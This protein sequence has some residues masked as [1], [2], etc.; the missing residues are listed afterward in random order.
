MAASGEGT[1]PEPESVRRAVSTVYYAVF[2]FIAQAAADCF[3]G[4]ANRQTARYALIYRSFDHRYMKA[5]CLAL[6]ASTLNEK[7][8]NSLGRTTVSRSIVNFPTIFP[9]LQQA[10]HTADY[11]PTDIFNASNV[12][13]LAESAETAIAALDDADPD[14]R[15]D[16]LALLMLRPRD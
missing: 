3:V 10:R 11:H 5:T 2:H 1:E 15:A 7:L 13:S 16:V 4:A 6:R 14:E 9:D 8:R 12:L